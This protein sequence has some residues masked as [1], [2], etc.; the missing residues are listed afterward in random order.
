MTTLHGPRRSRPVAWLLA[1][2]ILVASAGLAAQVIRDETWE[3][4]RPPQPLPAKDVTFPPYALKTLPN[5]L[6]VVAL[7]HH[8][9]PIVSL[10]LLVR[11]GSSQDPANKPGV[12]SLVGALLDQGTTTRSAQ[13]VATAIDDVGGALAAGGGTDLSYVNVVVMKDSFR[14]G[15]ELLA[16][17]ARNPAFAA[18]EIERQ[19][20]QAQSSI[21]V[22][23][24][25]PDYVAGAVIDRLIWGFHPY[26]RPGAGTV[27]SIGA[28]TRDDVLAFHQSWFVPNNAIIGVVGD[29]TAD[30]AFAEVERI[31][32]GWQRREL[33][34]LP[35]VEPPPPTR[36]VVIVD[37]PGAV[38]TEIR[39]GN[40]AIPRKH[41]DYTALDLAARV[42]GG[43][44]AN[45]LQRVLRTENGLT[46]AA[47]ADLQALKRGGA[48]VAQT[49]TRSEATGEA[50]RIAVDEVWRL[51]RER[52]HPLELAD[53][54]KYLNGHFPLTIE[55]PGEIATQILNVLFYD[56][57][58]E[59]LQT[60]RER[61]NA[62]T[63]DDIQ[64]V[65]RAYLF[66]SRLSIVL[67]GDAKLIVPQLR[68]VGFTEFDVVPL[69]ELDLA[70]VDL[71]R[72]PAQSPAVRR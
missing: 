5:G 43:E 15:L 41:G 6:Q 33:P 25:D 30:E 42:L 61:V 71:R 58:V 26:G 23:F 69:Q 40:L 34:A 18:T 67:V 59:D 35:P 52:V 22:S 3:R 55:T 29:V 51:Q 68:A 13:E 38:Q 14:F 64:R 16:D 50:L 31:M 39:L 36:R 53:A 2:S 37:R 9:L 8:E 28:M 44:G 11:A 21:R 70:S 60:Q 10:R 45:R 54:Q 56:L 46:Y 24:E 48:V 32:S 17:V 20:E 1:G 19:R 4:S 62:I 66:P 63:V 49:D 57:N 47:S 72:A 65:A 27:E 7:S 12:A